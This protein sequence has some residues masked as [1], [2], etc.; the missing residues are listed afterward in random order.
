MNSLGIVHALIVKNIPYLGVVDAWLHIYYYNCIMSKLILTFRENHSYF[1]NNYSFYSIIYTF[2]EL[3]FAAN[4]FL[5]KLFPEYF[6]YLFLLS[7]FY[8]IV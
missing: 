6:V 8:F 5:F 7:Q 2:I 4:T 1:R 3:V